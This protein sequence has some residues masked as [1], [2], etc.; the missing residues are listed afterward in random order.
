MKSAYEYNIDEIIEFVEIA[1]ASAIT[2]LRVFGCIEMEPQFNWSAKAK[3]RGELYGLR[4]LCKYDPLEE[5]PWS[6]F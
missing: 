1:E 3:E 5:T 4:D 6:L 2:E